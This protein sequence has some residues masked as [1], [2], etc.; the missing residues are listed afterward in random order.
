MAKI[1]DFELFWVFRRID[2]KGKGWIDSKDVSQFVI[3]NG[4]EIDP[5]MLEVFIN[6]VGVEK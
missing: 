2:S 4:Y 6:A 1:Q 5:R 3:D